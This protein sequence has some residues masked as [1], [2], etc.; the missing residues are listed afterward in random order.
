VGNHSAPPLDPSHQAALAV[1]RQVDGVALLAARDVGEP[2][3]AEAALRG[4]LGEEAAHAVEARRD[5]GRQRAE[6]GERG[7]PAPLRLAQH[8]LDLA[9]LLALERFGLLGESA[10]LLLED[11]ARLL[12]AL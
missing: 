3:R 4:E 7:L 5:R 12:G 1:A 9:L 2:A 8:A 6:L 10:H 11:E